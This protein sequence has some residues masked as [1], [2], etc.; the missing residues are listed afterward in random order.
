MENGFKAQMS[1]ESFKEK[2]QV[3]GTVKLHASTKTPGG[4]WATYENAEGSHSMAAS[5][6]FSDPQYLQRAKQRGL[7]LGQVEDGSWILFA[8]GAALETIMEM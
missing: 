2:Y 1:L 6:K 5:R 7:A 3:Y 4:F 8:K